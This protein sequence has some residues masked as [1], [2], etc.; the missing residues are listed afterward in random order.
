MKIK[1]KDIVKIQTTQSG[2][3]VSTILFEIRLNLRYVG[4]TNFFNPN[5]QFEINF[6]M[7]ADELSTGKLLMQ[8]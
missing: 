8:I 2:G 3:I 1:I 7:L 5:I 4:F 6:K